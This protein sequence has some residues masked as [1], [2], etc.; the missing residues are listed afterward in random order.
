MIYGPP[1]VGK[2]TVAQALQKITGFKIL[3][4]HLFADLVMSV[5]NRGNPVTNKL[6]QQIR[7]L[8]YKTS[9]ENKLNG[10]ITTFVYHHNE[11]ERE[12]RCILEYKKTLD[13]LKGEIFLVRLSCDIK[14]L[15]RRVIMPPRLVSTK[16]S[17]VKK[18]EEILKN[19][20][21]TGEAIINGI[22]NL[23]IDNTDLSPEKAA[24]I[25]KSNFNL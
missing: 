10:I 16:I 23:H 18:L 4:N 12:K 9:A 20:D 5:F 15:R 2:L 25:I 13:K 8:V 7:N 17:S 11:S 3:H 24:Q 22:K 1:A 21:M 19:D 6:N 14:E